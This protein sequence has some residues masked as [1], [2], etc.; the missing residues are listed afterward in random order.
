MRKMFENLPINLKKLRNSRNMSQEELAFF[1]GYS[2]KNISKWETGVSTPPVQTLVKICDLFELPNIETLC[3]DVLTIDFLNIYADLNV[4]KK[5]RLDFTKKDIE[6]FYMIQNHK[7]KSKFKINEYEI[8]L[9]TMTKFKEYGVI[10]EFTIVLNETE[11]ELEYINNDIVDKNSFALTINRIESNKIF[12]SNDVDYTNYIEQQQFSKQ[13]L[14]VLNFIDE[15][16]PLIF[17]L[18]DLYNKELI[19]SLKILYPKNRD[20]KKIIRTSLAKLLEKK[21]ITKEGYSIYK[22]KHHRLENNMILTNDIVNKLN[23]FVIIEISNCELGKYIEYNYTDFDF[24][25][26]KK[27]DLIVILDLYF[28]RLITLSVIDSFRIIINFE[29]D[30]KNSLKNVVVDLDNDV[31][32]MIEYM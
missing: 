4:V 1:L 12:F 26:L 18:C 30:K 25:H 16:M 9:L 29:I 28:H 20:V 27:N 23:K 2:S 5:N 3:N 22:K 17:E 32:I 14:L 10:S 13:T 11:F 6:F 19:E 24:L 21:V 15:A 8:V 7:S 31:E